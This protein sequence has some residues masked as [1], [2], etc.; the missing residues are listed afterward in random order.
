MFKIVQNGKSNRPNERWAINESLFLLNKPSK[1]MAFDVLKRFYHVSVITRKFISLYPVFLISSL[2]WEV[3]K[4]SKR[5]NNEWRLNVNKI[6]N[7][8]CFY[9]Y[10]STP[11]YIIFSYSLTV[12]NGNFAFFKTNNTLIKLIYEICIIT[13]YIFYV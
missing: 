5:S 9:S 12:L 10:C 1:V 4:T 6:Q 8:F 13:G 3:F 7:C 11:F 2:I